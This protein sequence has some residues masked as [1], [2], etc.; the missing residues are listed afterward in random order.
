MGTLE[1]SDQVSGIHPESK[2]MLNKE[3]NADNYRGITVL[4]CFGKLFTCIL[5]NRLNSYLEN[6]NVLCEE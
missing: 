1:P 4:S 5:N 2:T 3:K 6:Y